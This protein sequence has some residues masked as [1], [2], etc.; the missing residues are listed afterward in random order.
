MAGVLRHR[1]TRIVPWRNGSELS[2]STSRARQTAPTPAK[3]SKPTRLIGRSDR[4]MRA[5]FAY[6]ALT[7]LTLA[8]FAL[9]PDLDLAVAH[10]FYDGGGF[11]GHDALDKFGRD[12]FRVT[13]FVVL[14][15]FAALWLLKRLGRWSG[16]APSGRAMI[17]LIATIAI[18][19]GVV[20]N[21]ALK[22]HWHRPRP[23]QTQDFQRTGR[24]QAMV[25]RSGRMQEKLLVRLR[26]GGDRVLD[27]RAGECSCRRLSAFRRSSR[28]SLSA[29]QRASCGWHSAATTSATCCSAASSP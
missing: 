27:G 20:V 3:G 24:V 15:A 4:S 8:V 21:L 23:I 28:P 18:G 9:R 12:F 11:L 2:Q 25:R 16:W 14:A 1:A 10:L 7:A 6:V 29:S 19:P 13:P 26:R 22:D 17:F 5:F